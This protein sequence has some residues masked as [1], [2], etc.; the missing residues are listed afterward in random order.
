MARHRFKSDASE[1]IH[2]AAAGLLRARLIDRNAMKDYDNRCIAN[3]HEINV[4]AN[5]NIDLPLKPPV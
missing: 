5:V 4:R 3:E 1:A 2:S